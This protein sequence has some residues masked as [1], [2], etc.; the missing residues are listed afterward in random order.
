MI[1]VREFLKG[2]EKLYPLSV[3]CATDMADLL[4]RVNYL[5]G[6]YG[7]PLVVTSGYRPLPINIEVGGAE[8]SAH[9][10]C[11]AIDLGDEGGEFARWC[12]ECI[13]LLDELGL[14]MEDPSHTPGWVHLQTRRT[15]NNP[16]TP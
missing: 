6:I 12:L 14:Y 3:K 13:D 8:N 5:R 4:A 1:S 7:S 2:R 10:Y 16:F 11:Q 9:I 15:K